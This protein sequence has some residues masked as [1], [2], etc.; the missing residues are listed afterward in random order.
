VFESHDTSNSNRYT[1]TVG[2]LVLALVFTP[3]L[4]IVSRPVGLASATLA[5]A[6]SVLFVLLAWFNWNRRSHKAPSA[7]SR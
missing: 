2:L 7:V 6:C 4:L 1:F 5:L 3:A